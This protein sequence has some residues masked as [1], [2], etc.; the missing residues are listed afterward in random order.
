M[1]SMRGFNLVELIITTTIVVIFAAIAIPSYLDFSRR[2]YYSG[3]IEVTMLY[4]TAV[5]KCYESRRTLKGCNGGTHDIPANIKTPKENI[6]TLTVSNGVIAAIPVKGSGITEKDTYV[7]TPSIVKQEVSW[8]ASGV[9]V[10]K[11][12]TD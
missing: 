8:A 12:Y 3:V 5:E 7:L 6:A 4:K 9:A 1:K 10:D 2:D 11:N